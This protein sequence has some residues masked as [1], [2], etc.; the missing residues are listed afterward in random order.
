MGACLILARRN[1][2]NDSGMMEKLVGLC[3]AD[4][5]C[6]TVDT[7]SFEKKVRSVPVRAQMS[8]QMMLFVKSSLVRLSSLP[9][10]I[11][12]IIEWSTS[13]A[14]STWGSVAGCLVS[15]TGVVGKVCCGEVAVIIMVEL[16]SERVVLG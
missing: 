1:K 7:R 12:V 14:M 8:R 5:C 15:E 11:E 4:S 10:P 16:N 6:H 13:S 3:F 9:T 2:P